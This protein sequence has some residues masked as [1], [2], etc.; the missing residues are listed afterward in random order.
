MNGN[1]AIQEPS[2]QEMAR[3][4]AIQRLEYAMGQLNKAIEYARNGNTVAMCDALTRANGAF[5]D[6][7]V[8]SLDF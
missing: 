3:F 8:H 2:D 7:V 5:S 6:A 1:D 4:Y